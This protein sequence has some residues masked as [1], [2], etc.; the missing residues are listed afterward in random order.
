[1]YNDPWNWG[2]AEAVE[3]N[4]QDITL[5]VQEAV[6]DLKAKLVNGSITAAEVRFC[7]NY[8]MSV[9]NIEACFF[10]Y[11]LLNLK[12]DTLSSAVENLL[13]KVLK[14][15]RTER[16]LHYHTW[17]GLHEK[18]L[19]AGPTENAAQSIA[20]DQYHPPVPYRA[21]ARRIRK[22]DMI[23]FRD[24][25]LLCTGVIPKVYYPWV[26]TLVAY[27]HDYQNPDRKVFPFS[28]ANMNLTV[29]LNSGSICEGDGE[30]VARNDLILYMD[31]RKNEDLFP[32][33]M[34]GEI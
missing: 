15:E 22:G 27:P 31:W 26:F 8:L 13:K 19:I 16:Q 3:Q 32:K 5:R 20:W 11:S 28:P 25:L 9:R 6:S 1:M 7:R 12:A 14:D 24:C 23:K 21:A 10:W 17:L 2:H 4:R 34:R 29:F 30:P 18:W 33:L